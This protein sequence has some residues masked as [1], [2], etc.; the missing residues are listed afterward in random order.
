MFIKKFYGEKEYPMKK[1][2]V[3]AMVLVLAGTMV[4]A[5]GQQSG[6]SGSSGP[7][8]IT[9]LIRNLN[10]QFVKDYAEN[11]QRLAKEKGIELNLQDANNALDTQL[12]QLSTALNQGYRHFVIIPCES[13]LSE[14][15]NQM[16]NERGGAAVYSNTPPTTKSLKMGKNF[17]F[18]SSP[19]T[20]AGQFLGDI[21][22][23][24]FDKYPDKAPGKVL[25]M[26]LIQGMIGYPSTKYREIGMLESLEKHGYKVNYV[27]KDTANWSPDQAQAK[28][29]AWLGAYRGKFNIVVAQNDGMALGAVESLV[30]NGYTKD[31][32]DD[33]TILAVPVIGV[34][35]T[36]E[37]LN[38]MSQN[39]LYATVLQDSQAQSAV[40][41]DVMYQLASTGTV[42]G[43]PAGGI[44]PAT[45]VTDQD[46]AN[47][48]EVIG[49]CYLIPYVPVTKANY[50]NYLK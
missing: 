17:F 4:F 31:N 9:A 11:L 1:V 29:D 25:N 20:I 43:K 18:A 40:A 22:A 47:D 39:K 24:Y 34:D 5:G 38:S 32:A 30:Q 50:K 48:P 12:T 45:Q 28:M 42:L 14:Q 10:E 27:A 44:S 13:E 33:G 23:E 8:K 21:I 41:F 3:A 46:P 35:A 15:M 7:V 36:M 6:S 16:I 37:A 49:Q 19:E 26:L 2:L